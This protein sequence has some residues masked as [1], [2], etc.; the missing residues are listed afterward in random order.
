MT[1]VSNQNYTPIANWCKL[2]YGMT[3]RNDGKKNGKK[4]TFII[5][6]N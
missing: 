6:R 2:P 5:N 1:Y 3:F 4:V